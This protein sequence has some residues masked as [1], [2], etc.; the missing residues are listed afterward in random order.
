MPKMIV[1]SEP[2][3]KSSFMSTSAEIG[4]TVLCHEMDPTKITLSAFVYLGERKFEYCFRLLILS[5]SGSD[6]D[7]TRR[8]PDNRIQS[9]VSEKALEQFIRPFCGELATIETSTAFEFELLAQEFKTNEYLKE[10]QDFIKEAGS[11]IIPDHILFLRDHD[12]D[13]SEKEAELRSHFWE[14]SDE[15]L[16]KLPLAILH[17]TL[18]DSGDARNVERSFGF[19]LKCLDKYGSP[20]SML[21]GSIRLEDITP[22]GLVELSRRQFAWALLPSTNG[23]NIRSLIDECAKARLELERAEKQLTAAN[24]EI[25]ELKN[26]LKDV[27]GRVDQLMTFCGLQFA[28]EIAQDKFSTSPKMRV[29]ACEFREVITDQ[30]WQNSLLVMKEGMKQL[31][32]PKLVNNPFAQWGLATAL[33]EQPGR[34]PEDL[35]RAR[36]LNIE[37]AT[38]GITSAQHERAVTLRNN[39]QLNDAVS[40]FKTA[41]DAG[42]MFSQ[43]EYG[44]WQLKGLPGGSPNPTEAEKYLRMSADSGNSTAQDTLGKLLRDSGTRERVALGEHYRQM[45]YK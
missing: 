10:I 11:A 7:M 8:F 31:Q 37:A 38:G 22:E 6:E 18:P 25:M 24:A 29:K 26:G 4:T 13:A 42:N 44:M 27:N 28:E 12:K 40:L 45:A 21:C 32:A 33:Q 30:K 35:Q 43:Y 2:F 3:S 36:A 34:R 9:K 20:A 15:S 23:E 17:R 19:L 39:G 16:V 5:R 1:L 14:C 41:A